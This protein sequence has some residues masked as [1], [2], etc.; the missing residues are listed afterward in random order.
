MTAPGINFKMEKTM[1]KK[2][3]SALVRCAFDDGYQMATSYDIS[4]EDLD[5]VWD[6]SAASDDLTAYLAALP[7]P[8]GDV[9]ER[10]HRL[11]ESS[12]ALSETDAPAQGWRDISTAPKDT[13]ILV[14]TGSFYELAHFNTLG[15]CWWINTTATPDRGENALNRNSRPTHW[16]PLPPAPPKQGVVR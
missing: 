15:D 2:I 3:I 10:S 6:R 14:Y 13:A 11:L 7:A 1:D 16:V 9:V 8:D 5:S 12:A 4:Q